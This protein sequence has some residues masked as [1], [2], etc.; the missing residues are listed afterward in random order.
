MTVELPPKP[1]LTEIP[2]RSAVGESDDRATTDP[3]DPKGRA[4]PWR[5]K[6]LPVED[7]RSI[8]DTLMVTLSGGALWRFAAL[9]VLS[10][11]VASIGLLQNSAA[12]V[13]GAMMIAPLMAPIMGIAACL[14]MGWGHRLLRGLAL[15]AVS[16]MV[17]VGVGWITATLLPAT[18]TGLPSEVVARSSPD[19]RDLLVAMSAGAVGALATVHKK[20]SAALPGVAVA[21][22]VVPPAGR[23]RR[24]ARARTATVG[25]RCRHPVFDEPR[26]HRGDGGGG[27]PAERTGPAPQVPHPPPPD[28][29]VAGFGGGQRRGGCHDPHPA[30]HRAYRPCP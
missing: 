24:P 1:M 7:R 5:P 8:M 15:V 25:P 10:S 16:A 29:R 18:G 23:G 19:I 17:A 2:G 14:I 28:R 11:M 30:V 9:M 20:I 26:R 13:I 21:V 22:A 4:V 3:T 6:L 12:V 27:L